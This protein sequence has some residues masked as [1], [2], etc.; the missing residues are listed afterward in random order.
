MRL[1]LDAAASDGEA[2]NALSKLRQSL[3]KGGP[4]S[5]DLV[6]ALENAGFAEREQ[7][8]LPPKPSR[9]DYG[10]CRIPFG[11]KKGQLFMDTAPYELRNIRRWCQS[12]PELALKFADLIS[13]I[14]AY[15]G[16]SQASR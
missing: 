1:V 2:L 15:L 14:E 3:A 8:P 6:D 7:A 16:G 11:E 13:D 9:P 5:H 4:D 10:L 12:K